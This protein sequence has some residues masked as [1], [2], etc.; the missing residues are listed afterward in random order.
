MLPD[1][2]ELEIM[3]RSLSARRELPPGF[4]VDSI[5]QSPSNNIMNK[6]ARS[7]LSLYS[8]SD[9]TENTT[10]EDEMRIAL[11]L[12]AKMPILMDGA[13]QA[14]RHKYD[15]ASIAAGAV[16]TKDV[17]ANTVVGGVPAKFIRNIE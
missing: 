14:K 8:Y 16:V 9:I 3:T 4:L 10:I 12:I 1:A 17:P 6:L 15:N 13:Y 2:K 11:D 7:I 5:M